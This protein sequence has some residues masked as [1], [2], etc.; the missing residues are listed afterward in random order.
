MNSS[1][2]LQKKANSMKHEFATN[3]CVHRTFL[4]PVSWKPEGQRDARAR[5]TQREAPWICNREFN[6]LVLEAVDEGLSSLGDSPKQMIYLVLEKTF[7]VK[8]SEIPEKV[9]EFA[10]ALEQIF[11]Q[12]A[13][14]VEIQ[15]MRRLHDKVGPSFTYSPEKGDL[16]FTEYVEAARLLR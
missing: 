16:L 11:G 13:K 8:R 1:T 10:Y 14:I 5:V 2:K 4:H 15:I 12:G 9:E 6:K 7:K 3:P